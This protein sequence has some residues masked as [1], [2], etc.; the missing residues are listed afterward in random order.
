MQL[1]PLHPGQAPVLPG[2]DQA[3]RQFAANRRRRRRSRSRRA[4]TARRAAAA[5]DGLGGAG[6]DCVCLE[7]HRHPARACVTVEPCVLPLIL[8]LRGSKYRSFNSSLL[9]LSDCLSIVYPYTRVTATL[10]VRYHSDLGPAW[11]TVHATPPAP[12]R[13]V[14][15]SK[16]SARFRGFKS[17]KSSNESN[18]TAGGGDDGDGG[19]GGSNSNSG[20]LHLADVH[21]DP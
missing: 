10:R 14:H 17:S 12:V 20:G 13:A 21:V 5:F 19:G 2:E 16:G 9:P 15:E 3:R 1:V 6:P 11:G 4:A 8:R 7:E 18:N